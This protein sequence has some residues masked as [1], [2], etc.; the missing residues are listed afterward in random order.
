MERLVK[1]SKPLT[2][3]VIIGSLV[4]LFFLLIFQNVQLVSGRA[5]NGKSPFL[6]N[7]SANGL[8]LQ[9]TP[10]H[11]MQTQVFSDGKEFTEFEF[12]NSI[13]FDKPGLPQV[14]F[15]SFVVGVPIGSTVSYRIVDSEF[16]DFPNVEL[17]PFPEYTAVEGTLVPRYIQDE[18]AYNSSDIFPAERVQISKGSF[19]RDQQIVNISVAAAQY[20]PKSNTLRKFN[21]IVLQLNFTG[22]RVAQIS[23]QILGRSEERLYKSVLVNYN[24]AQ[25]WRRLYKIPDVSLSKS[26]Q[27]QSGTYYKFNIT[28]EGIYRI[29]GDFLRSNINNLDLNSIDPAKIQVF[30]HGGKE[31]PRDIEVARP[32]GLVENAIVVNDGGD[33]RFDGDDTILFYG[34]GVEGWEFDS[35]SGQFEHYINHYGF[36]NVYWLKLDGARDGKRMQTVRS[37]EIASQFVDSYAG[38]VFLEEE[39]SNPV[40]SGMHWFGRNF[41]VD[42]FGRSNSWT[43]DLPNAITSEAARFNFRFAAL[44]TG[45]HTFNIRMNNNQIGVKTFS[46][47]S[48]AF[49]I[50]L[51]VATS[52]A[53]YQQANV[54]NP[55]SNTLRLDYSHSSTTGQ[56]FLDW[57]EI[58]YSARMI[59]IEN[60]LIFAVQPT[61]GVQTY[62]VSNFSGPEVKMFDVSDFEHIKIFEGFSYSNGNV[63]FADTQTSDSPKRY[64]ILNPA[65]YK[66]IEDLER[67]EFRN[68]RDPQ[69]SLNPNPMSDN[70]FI[71]I[72]HNDFRAEAERLESLRENANPADQLQTEVVLIS[73]IYNN[74]SSGM[75]DVT[76]IRDFLKYT[77]ENWAP[78]PFYVLL[79]G[80]GD[81]DYKNISSKD[82]LNWI[83]PFQTDDLETNS[84]IEELVSRTNDSWY[85][86]LSPDN[87]IN[88]SRKMDMAIGR[89]NAQTITDAK[90]AI[91]KIIAYESQTDFGQW[92]N[93]VTIVG[94]DELINNGKPSGADVVH[95]RQAE[96][97][98]EQYIPKHFDLQKIYLSEYPKVRSEA[99]GGVL[100]PA[101]KEALIQAINQGTLLVNFVGH[102][103][104]Q[105]W[106]HEQIF[107]QADNARIQNQGK[108]T[109]F[110][111]ATCDWA[112]YDGPDRVSQAEDL[113]LA[114]KRGAI[115]IISAAR[116][117]FAHT[118]F[119][120]SKKFYAALF[121][122]E[123]SIIRIGDAF[124]EARLKQPT[125]FQVNDEKY[126]VFGDPTL[127][128]AIPQKQAVI[129]KMTPDSILALASVE[130]EGEIMTNGQT[131]DSFNGTAFLNVFDSKKSIAHQPE[132]GSIQRYLL[133]GNS[134]YR[135]TVPVQNGRFKSK[136]IV[137]KDIS[138]G[139]E[140]AKASVYFWNDETDGSGS[141]NNIRVSSS[142]SELVDD[143]G[144]EIK[145]YFKEHQNFTTGDIVDE[146]ITLVIELADTV[147]GIN[148]A[149]EIGHQLTLSIDPNEETC[150]SQLNRFKGVST[151][152]LTPIFNFNEGDHLRGKIEF[153]LQFPSEV[154]IGGSTIPCADFDDEQ[155]HTLVVKAWDNAN[156]SSTASVEVSI[157]HE[158]G[159]VLKEV[160]NYPNP[161]EDETTFTFFLNRDA[162]VE[163]KIYTV[164]GQLIKK[165]E[166][167]FARNGFNMIEWDGRDEQGDTPANG[168]YLYKIIAKAAGASNSLQKEKL[169]R[170]AIIR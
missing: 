134:I 167:P 18:S 53:N 133:P 122:D 104:S 98:A 126:H 42:E 168:V 127:R 88:G 94:D 66:G 7:E 114:E 140:L 55:G 61:S 1:K 30:N 79:L 78:R 9:L 75:A 63:T 160:L 33:G 8:T 69:F 117:V 20:F 83:P 10:E 148:I 123:T 49:G 141:L 16:E 72:T 153:S 116:L 87:D 93:T 149:G 58:L 56:A 60:E 64:A 99:S 147:S 96:S 139:G 54:V 106:T 65:E 35:A 119:E 146:N 162:E 47:R 29:T 82:D 4:I 157:I 159:L 166:Y 57:V 97:I 84:L 68:L 5:N 169:G 27:T 11:W 138:Y 137:P 128:L 31:L 170:L 59:A 40:R 136:F 91:D 37:A 102:G 156:N 163:V 3:N 155:R 71:I 103:N 39:R 52:L 95:I 70:S 158:E 13:K 21:K 41:S 85:T 22:S 74:F 161:F 143:A 80:D 109:F 23:P 24:Q 62:R 14:P 15:H 121:P 28:E 90:N 36:N 107:T 46:G 25:K 43:L 132:S 120:F 76:A 142:T 150:L 113:L 131:D 26:S 81:Y 105:L 124:L 111:A 115:A 165:L 144:P 110:V 86:Y 129:T 38:M 17:L 34:R 118:N 164:A 45:S 125:T 32:D 100:K 92:R 6:L 89:I 44:N 12:K 135:G 73:D 77:Y 19:F 152:D 67:I 154:E 101:A 145:I 151:I 2:R 108:L 50:Y 130:I 112:L 51:R 48:L